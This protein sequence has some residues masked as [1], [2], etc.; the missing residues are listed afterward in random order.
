MIKAN[1]VIA[2]TT[3]KLDFRDP[4]IT[5]YNDL[6]KQVE[7]ST[8]EEA[9]YHKLAYLNAWLDMETKLPTTEMLK[10]KSKGKQHQREDDQIKLD[11][12]WVTIVYEQM[13]AI[14][15]GMKSREGRTTEAGVWLGY[16]RFMVSTHRGRLDRGSS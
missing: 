6:Y 5:G 2:K 9:R 8:P 14:L 4:W 3:T 1:K 15:S 7:Q 11:P 12:K 10:Q 16:A 13:L